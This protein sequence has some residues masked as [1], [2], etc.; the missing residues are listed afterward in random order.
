MKNL[1][2]KPLVCATI[3]TL[4]CSPAALAKSNQL[5]AFAGN[6]SGLVSLASPGGT[7]A[8]TA[9]VVIKVPKNGKSAF[10]SYAATIDSGGS[11]S[12]L[13]ADFTLAKNKTMSTTDLGIGIAGTN[14]AHPGT[15]NW[16]QKKRKLTMFATN[17]DMNL[18]G[19]GVVK[20]SRKK[21]KLTLTLVSSDAGGSNVFTTVLSAKKPK[22]NK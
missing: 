6:Y 7:S 22:V 13:P 17:G 10:I 19:I 21:R 2:A 8:G 14:N 1:L 4:L 18:T 15:G 5:F 3:A 16:S 20:D 9:V 12:V 11:T